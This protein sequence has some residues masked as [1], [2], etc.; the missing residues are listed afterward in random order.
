MITPTP[1]PETCDSRFNAHACS[2]TRGHRGLHC[3]DESPATWSDQDASVVRDASPETL[4]AALEAIVALDFKQTER[5]RDDFYS[6]PDRFIRAWTIA[7]E[8]LARD[9]TFGP[10]N[11][12]G[13][14]SLHEVCPKCEDERDREAG[15]PTSSPVVRD[16]SPEQKDKDLDLRLHGA[17]N[18]DRTMSALTKR[19]ATAWQQIDTAPKDGTRIDLWLTVTASPRSF[20][21]SDAWRVIDCYWHWTKEGWY[22][23]HE[24]EEKELYGPYVTHWMPLP[25]PPQ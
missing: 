21:I 8:A 18:G 4:R 12:C 17:A 7:R 23:L 1:E 10:C 24:G 22:H 25:E 20:G 5:G 3:D 16:A 14:P 2:R 6:G 11:H 15:I 19:P 13:A 9:D